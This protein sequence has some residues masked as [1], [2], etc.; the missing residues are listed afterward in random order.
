MLAGEGAP[1]AAQARVVGAM[2][3]ELGLTPME[4]QVLVLACRGLDREEIGARLGLKLGTVKIHIGSLL[5]K[6][7]RAGLHP[8]DLRDVVRRAHERAGMMRR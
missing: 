8:V 7:R 3:N 1:D 5:E 2:A 6:A 4:G